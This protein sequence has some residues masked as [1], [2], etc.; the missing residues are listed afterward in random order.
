MLTIFKDRYVRSDDEQKTPLLL[1]NADI[2]TVPLRDNSVDAVIVVAVFLHNHKDVVEKAMSEIKRVLKPDG[3][4]LVYSSFPRAATFMGLQGASYQML[5]N[6]LGKPF[7]NGP[8]RYYRK[9]EIM[10]LLSGFAEVELHPVGF[11]VLPKTLIFLPGILEKIYRCGIANPVNRALER[12]TPLSIKAYFA[13]HYD[14]VAT[15]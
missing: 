11:S 4:L 3:V 14:V 9:S 5:L 15:R 12:I 7:K 1:L 10:R 13:V 8:V 2:H 6:L